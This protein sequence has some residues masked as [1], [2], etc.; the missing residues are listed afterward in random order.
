MLNIWKNACIK[1]FGQGYMPMWDYLI[2]EVASGNITHKEVLLLAENVMD[3][4][5]I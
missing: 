4:N 2:H 5:A 1:Y 3:T